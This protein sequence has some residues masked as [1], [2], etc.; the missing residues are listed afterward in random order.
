MEN[1]KLKY[2]NDVPWEKLLR[3]SNGKVVHSLEQLPL[4][5]QFSDDEV[6]ADHVTDQKNDFSNWIKDVI[7]DPEL[8]EKIFGI[9]S[10]EEFIKVIEQSVVEIKNYV[11]PAPSAVP[12]V[13]SPVAQTV[14]VSVPA[15]SLTPSTPVP[16][17]PSTPV[18]SPVSI[19]SSPFFNSPPSLNSPP[20][21][22]TVLD[23]TP[24]AS[25]AVSPGV[26]QSVISASTPVSVHLG[27]SSVP[28][29]STIPP[30]L[31]GINASITSSIT[32]VPV[33]AQ[34]MPT[35]PTEAKPESKTENKLVA[36]SE[37]KPEEVYEFEDVFKKLLDDVESDIFVWDTNNG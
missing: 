23:A 16:N 9:R 25:P 21:I 5:I 12:A 4:V 28:V 26:I 18:V 11:P 10:K 36:V 19:N 1:P 27:P 35:I 22:P 34:A 2:L 30:V 15:A 17:V 32:S 14:D 24:T 7:G 8:A 3:L 6:F 33:A 31:S 20:I 29:V 13:S 37:T